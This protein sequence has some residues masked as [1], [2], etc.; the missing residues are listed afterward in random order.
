MPL[1]VHRGGAFRPPR[2]ILYGAPKVGKSTF[3][4]EAEYPV[5][6]TTEDGVA[7]IAVDQTSPAKTWEEF[8]SNVKA[9]AVEKHAYKTLVI[10]TLNGA[11]QLAAQHVCRKL[12][13]DDWGPKGFASF[14]QGW[15]ATSEEMR[16]L[17]DPLDACRER[18]MWVLMLAHTGLL[19]VKNPLEG[20]FTKY[21]PDVD[22]K[23]WA[24]FHGWADV[25]LRADYEYAVIN[26]DGGKGKARGSNTRV[27][28]CTGSAAE[29]AGTRVGYTLPETLP[30]S[31]HA[32]V[33]AL[34]QVSP[35][36]DGIRQRWSL[37]SDTE[38]AAALKWLGIAA[39]A[40]L[41]KAPSQ[42][43]SSCLNSLKTKENA[44]AAAA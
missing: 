25:I 14:G 29:D 37:L 30:L 27:L 23:I 28:R 9:V 36:V 44:A 38:Q 17:I 16:A 13:R 3:G 31:W 39:T 26:S 24:R 19:A 2:T 15:S 5:F 21:A 12:F 7:G 40:D 34:G 32:F 1:T 33:E 42:K 18:G 11:A 43:L 41:S 35:V 22:R 4:S 8:M 20:D 6:V 10:D